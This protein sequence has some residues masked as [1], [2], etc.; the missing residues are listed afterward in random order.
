MGFRTFQPQRG[1]STK[2]DCPR[3]PERVLENRTERVGDHGV[4]PGEGG[5]ERSTPRRRLSSLSVCP[6][7]LQGC[8]A[9]TAGPTASFRPA[10]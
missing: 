4:L 7:H 5:L 6:N 10:R 8:Q 9:E 3:E 2:P 1:Q